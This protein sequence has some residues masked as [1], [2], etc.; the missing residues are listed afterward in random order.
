MF[1]YD[2]RPMVKA[3]LSS[4]LHNIAKLICLYA[5]FLPSGVFVGKECA[6]TLRISDRS[7]RNHIV[8]SLRL[9]Q[10]LMP[11]EQCWPSMLLRIEKNMLAHKKAKRKRLKKGS[12]QNRSQRSDDSGID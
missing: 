9:L 3:V 1:S 2:V 11:L 5:L 12:E 10:V 6:K 7:I 4:D 8:Q